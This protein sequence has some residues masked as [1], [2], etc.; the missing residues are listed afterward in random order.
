MRG[1]GSVWSVLQD[2]ELRGGKAGVKGTSQG[3]GVYM[4]NVTTRE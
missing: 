4:G 1:T 2:S 3:K